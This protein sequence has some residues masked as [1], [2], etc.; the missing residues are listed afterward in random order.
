MSSF[1]FALAASSAAKFLPAG[2]HPSATEARTFAAASVASS[3]SVPHAFF[4][5]PSRAFSAPRTPVLSSPT[6]LRA[7]WLQRLRLTV[8]NFARL[9]PNWDSYGARPTTT[10]AINSALALARKAASNRGV[11]EPDVHPTPH[12][13]ITFVWRTRGVDAEIRVE[14]DGAFAV[15]SELSGGQTIE[16]SR[17]LKAFDVVLAALAARR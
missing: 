3:A 9:D 2:L 17:P 8:A 1:P 7:S 5:Q 15:D 16:D 13:G 4:F 14:S 6:T 10:Q 12:G 11:P